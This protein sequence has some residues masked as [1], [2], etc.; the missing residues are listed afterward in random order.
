MDIALAVL[1]VLIAVALYAFLG[2]LL[3]ALLREGR[4]SPATAQVA[5]LTRLD[6][7]GTAS[8]LSGMPSSAPEG[9]LTSASPITSPG[10]T[11]GVRTYTLSARAT[12]WVGRD[13][14][15]TICVSNEFASQHHA[16]I[17]WRADKKA[18]WIEDN[19]SRNGTEVNGEKVMRCELSVGDVV[20]IAGARFRFDMPE[21]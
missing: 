1:R 15:C 2:V 17:E 16:R 10:V 13:P 9:A 3:W 5:M 7:G 11:G 14:N 12:A 6:A 19:N 8:V 4:G 20:T 21:T 18:W